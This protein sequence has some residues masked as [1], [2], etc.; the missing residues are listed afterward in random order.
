M[1]I[2]LILVAEVAGLLAVFLLFL[3][4]LGYFKVI[5]LPNFLPQNTPSTAIGTNSEI[6]NNNPNSAPVSFAKLRSQAADSEMQKYRAY[7]DTLSKPTAQANPNDFVSDAV[8]SGYDSKTV[9]VITKEGILN[10]GFDQNTL[11]QKQPI[12]QLQTNTT[13]QSGAMPNAIAYSSSADFFRNVVFGST[14]QISFS[15][16]NLKVTQVNYIEAIQPIP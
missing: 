3:L 5:T 16:P 2:A 8:F 13:I 12:P 4:V 7:A 15:K 9:Q 6:A 10:L 14:V 11:F 1:K